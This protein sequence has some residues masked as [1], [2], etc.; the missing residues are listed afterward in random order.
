MNA[1]PESSTQ[2]MNAPPTSLIDTHCHL[3]LM[4]E[5]P[6]AAV[7]TATAAG[8][9]AVITIGID[10]LSCE[11][12]VKLA[13]EFPC[14]YAAVG[15][16][17]HEGSAVDKAVLD[18]LRQLAAHPKVVAIGETGLDFYRNRSPHADQ[19]RAFRNHIELARELALPLVVHDREAHEQTL[20]ALREARLPD[21]AVVMHCFSGD[22]DMARACL[23]LGCYISIAGPVTFRNARRLQEVVAQL[24]LDRLLLETDSPF[25]APH[26]HRGKPNSP[27]MLPLI[28]QAIADL[29]GLTTAAVASATAANAQRAF[30]LGDPEKPAVEA[31]T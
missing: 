7:A 11:S 19:E 30:K 12:A 23:D 29:Q 5:G 22:L 28:A 10:L 27:A 21:G 20:Q 16:H 31:G 6:A 14:V 8:V 2:A 15:M 26:P 17:P 13:E 25:L 4:E 24:P 9:D 3:D 1:S 18:R